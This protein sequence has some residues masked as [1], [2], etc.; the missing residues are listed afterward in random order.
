[1]SLSPNHA[2]YV[3]QVSSSI[4]VSCPTGDNRQLETT[5]VS[6]RGPV[7]R[8]TFRGYWRSL[9]IGKGSKYLMWKSLGLALARSNQQWLRKKSN[10][11]AGSRL[12]YV[13]DEL[14]I[15]SGT[16]NFYGTTCAMCGVRRALLLSV[17]SIDGSLYYPLVG[18]LMYRPKVI[19]PSH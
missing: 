10:I 16:T 7:Y 8:E 17:P 19:G 15:N 9:G 3:Q 1:M 13:H 14:L 18:D 2:L 12:Q 11:M 5:A 4:Y 6:C